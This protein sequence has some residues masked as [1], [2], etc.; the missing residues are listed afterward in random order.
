[1]RLHRGGGASTTTRLKSRASVYE[2]TDIIRITKLP[3]PRL[4]ASFRSIT[5]DTEHPEWV[6]TDNMTTRKHDN[7]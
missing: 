6:R 4:Q 2:R 5:I 3:F 1:M 7:T